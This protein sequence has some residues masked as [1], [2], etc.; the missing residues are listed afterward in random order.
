MRGQKDKSSRRARL[1]RFAGIPLLALAIVFAGLKIYTDWLVRQAEAKYPPAE[2]VVVEGLP[3][4]Y[5]SEGSGR[6]VVFIHGGGGKLQDFALSPVFDLAAA[7]YQVVLVDRP[8]LGYSERPRDEDATPAV[9]ARLIHKALLKLGIEK[10]VLVGQSWGGVIALEY[11]LDYPDD[12][13]GIV[14]LGSAPYPREREPDPFL[15]IVRIPVLGDL[16]LQTLYVPIGRHIVAPAFLEA[17]AEYFAPLDA[18]PSS[19][20]D[21]TIELGL[22][23]SH[24]KADADEEVIIPASLESIS[25]RFGEISVPVTIVAGS[26]DTHAIEQAPRLDEDIP[27]SQVS[28]VED[29]HHFIWFSRPEMVIDAIGETWTWADELGTSR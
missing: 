9:Q 23:P 19:Y 16:V 3:L 12:L 10:P 18:V 4:H 26:L 29:A 11:A 21:T 5:L 13:S 17:S 8:G 1:I 14:L 22:R 15:R 24:V 27:Y 7:D 6:P 25:G 2:F 20:L 28:V